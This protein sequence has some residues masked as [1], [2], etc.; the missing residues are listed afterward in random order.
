MTKATGISTIIILIVIIALAYLVYQSTTPEPEEIV[1][2]EQETE[3]VMSTSTIE[4]ASSSDFTILLDSNLT[5][6]FSWMADFDNEFIKL[7]SQEFV[8]ADAGT[9]TDTEATSTDETATTTEQG[10]GGE[11]IVDQGDQEKFE[12]TALKAGNTDITFTYS[13]P[14][15]SVQPLETIIYQ[16]IITDDSDNTDDTESSEPPEDE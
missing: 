14:W 6:G 5:T 12:F 7:N 11:M 13:K 1:Q 16:I 15:E 3:T 10:T 9:T 8:S 4:V 2:E